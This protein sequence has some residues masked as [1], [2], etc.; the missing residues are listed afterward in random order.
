MFLHSQRRVVPVH[1]V[2]NFWKG[3]SVQAKQVPDTTGVQGSFT[4]KGM[5]PLIEAHRQWISLAPVSLDLNRE[6]EAH[7]T[8]AG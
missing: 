2:L 7:N 3:D 8:T 5:K 1:G 4:F 6:S